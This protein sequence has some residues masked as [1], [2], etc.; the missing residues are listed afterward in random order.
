[1]FDK[2]NAKADDQA[3]A[4]QNP[5]PAA[6]VPKPAAQPARNA[7][8]I[9]SAIKIDGTISGEENLT[10]EGAVKGAVNLPGHEVLVGKSG[11]VAANINAATVSIEGTVKGD[12]VGGKRVV[13]TPDGRVEGNISSPR[14]NL[15][16]GAK[17]KGSIDMHPETQAAPAAAKRPP[18]APTPGPAA[19]QPAASPVPPAAKSPGPR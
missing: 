18:A 12:I 8:L 16:E 15:Q 10:I 5:A 11:Q 14:I 17:F 9:G 4:T 6:Y 3:D 1:M 2:R 13:L 7:A 19:T